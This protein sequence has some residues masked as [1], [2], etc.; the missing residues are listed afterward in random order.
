[1]RPEILNPLFQ[2]LASLKGVGPKLAPKLGKLVGPSGETAR[3]AVVGD[4]LLH[5][6]THLIDRSREELITT[7]PE[8]A[9]VT[10]R[11]RVDRHRPAPPN[12]RGPYRIA[13][14]DESGELSVSYF[15]AEKAWLEKLFPVGETRLVSGRVEWFNGA[16]QMVHPDHVVSVEDADKLPKM[17]PVYPMTEG[18]SPRIMRRAI[19]GALERLPALPEWQDGPMLARERWPGFAEALTRLHRPEEQSDLAEG[20]PF[21]TRLAY[22]EL[23][24]NQL[25]LA[26]VRKS[27]RTAVGRARKPTGEILKRLRAALPFAL[28][29]S[30][31]AAIADVLADM[32]SPNRMI[33]LV[34]GDVGSG[35]TMVALFAC[36]A[37][38]EAGGQA[39]IMAP[40]ELLARQHARS[41]A[42]LCE[43]AGLR[44]ACITGSDRPK[45][46]KETLEAVAIGEVDILV[47]THA[48]FQQGVLFR[49][50][51]LAVV[52]EQH[53]FGVHQRLA[54]SAKGSRTDLLVMTAT[55]IPRTLLL[56]YF[57]DMDVSRLTEKP[58][59]RKPIATRSVS[60]DRLDEVVER[61]GTAVQSEGAKAY[62]V[63]PLVEESEVSDL[64]AAEERFA[65]LKDV[66]GDMVALVHGRMKAAEKDEAMRRFQSGE[67]RV[68]VAT[69]V[70]EVG[71]DVPD[72]TIIVIEHAERFGLAQLHQLRG[73]VGRGSKAST[74]LLL[75]KAPL[76]ETAKAR[77]TVM[78]ESEDG[79]RIAEEDLKLR[80]GGELLGTRQSGMPGFR[81]VRPEIHGHLTE[82]A[83]DDAALVLA[84][85]PGLQTER[86]AALRTLLYLFGRD[87]AV[88]L[89]RAG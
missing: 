54:L 10:L 89:I 19:E 63:C 61:I 60:L 1:M 84:K 83:R 31:D 59:G 85:D 64:A 12:G 75:F 88:R 26:L 73:R 47:G 30:Q 28:T 37:A 40:T 58:A 42:P 45:A 79:F 56:S 18:V 78:R 67:A 80:G 87:E 33:R 14:H 34:Q 71:V 65:V 9:I 44:L 36:A 4:L 81:L 8:G 46:R 22:D 72:A 32:G 38:V 50:L 82:M 62:W 21:L 23:L 17:E 13:V 86:G 70:I 27:L 29:G 7:A 24:A 74:C 3:E 15:H 69:T 11:V 53:R 57:G 43:A 6:P 68:L 77:L 49:D 25:A 48:L 51:A 52:D 39:S 41:I 5:V 2:P 16:P 55:P 66:F 76:G 35:K 20:N